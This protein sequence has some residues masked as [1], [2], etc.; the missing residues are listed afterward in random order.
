MPETYVDKPG[1]MK[2][3]QAAP[4]TQKLKQLPGGEV[5]SAQKSPIPESLAAEAATQPAPKPVIVAARQAKEPALLPR[6]AKVQGW[7]FLAPHGTSLDDLT[8]PEF[9]AGCTN[10]LRR[11]PGD[12]PTE[13][14]VSAEDGSFWAEMVVIDCGATWAKCRFK[15]APLVLD[16]T[17]TDQISYAGHTISFAAG[18]W[19]AVR[20]ADHQMVSDGHATAQSALGWLEDHVRSLAA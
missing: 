11:R 8:R 10:K 6:T 7:H 20:D 17:P 16:A 5:V 3:Q 2:T 12:A 9:W 13:I 19:R 15:Y 14:T 4:K 18:S 1:G